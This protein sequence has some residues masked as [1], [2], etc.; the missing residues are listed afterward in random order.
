M[1]K[2]N[3]Y[4][5][6]AGSGKTYQLVREFLRICLG[7]GNPRQ[8]MRILAITFTNK[9]ANEMKV[10]IIDQL[11]EISHR[12]AA[13]R[14]ML[15]HLVEDLA[16]SEQEISLR[17]RQCLSSILHEYSAFSVSTIDG[18]TNRLIRSF[19]RDLQIGGNYEVEMESDEMLQEAVDEL[20][21]NLTE[22]N[23]ITD[24]ILGFVEEQLEEGRSPRPEHSLM[25]AGKNL[26]MEQAFHYLKS[27]RHLDPP[28]FKAIIS[29][30]RKKKAAMEEE[31]S[32]KAIETL[33]YIH[34]HGLS[35]ADFK[36]GYVY[37]Y[38]VKLTQNNSYGWVPGKSVQKVIDGEDNFYAA[39]KKRELQPLFEPI[40]QELHERLLQLSVLACDHYRDHHLVSAV[41]A[42]IYGTAVITQ[43]DQQL[44]KVKEDTN[45]LPIGE[46]NKL[47]SEKLT[48]E[49][50]DYLFE[51]L[52]ERYRYFF[53]D[54]FQDTSRLQWQ[55]LLPL[56]NNAMASG[57][58]VMLVGDAKQ[59]IY[60]WRG[61][62]VEQF[63]DLRDDTDLSNKILS[64]TELKELYT[65]LTHTL[66]TNY[67]SLATVVEFNNEFFNV[68]AA[69]QA[70]EDFGELYRQSSQEV[71]HAS[72]GYVQVDL[73][74]YD[75]ADKDGYILQQCQECEQIIRDAQARGY[76]YQEMAILVRSNGKG[77]T[78][79]RHLLEM[80][81]PVISPDALSLAGSKPVKALV[82]ALEMLNQIHE[83]SLRYHF[84]DFL[85]ELPEVTAQFPEK[86]EFIF[87]FS[88]LQ[89]GDLTGRLRKLLPGLDLRRLAL[90]SLGDLVYELTR[91]LSIDIQN[92]PFLHAFLDQVRNF[93][94]RQG[95]D[96][97][98]FVR[99]W[100]E[101]GHKINIS[102]PDNANAVQVMSVHKSKGLEFKICVLAFADWPT[103]HE[104]GVTRKWLSLE[105][106]E[107]LELPA[108]WINLKKDDTGLADP[109]YTELYARNQ[110]QVSFDNINLLY[111]AFT[112]AREELYVLGARG[113]FGESQRV[114]RYLE[115]ILKKHEVTDTLVLGEK[116][117]VRAKEVSSSLDFEVYKADSYREKL[118]VVAEA[119]EQWSGGEVSSEIA[120]GKTVH[121]LLAEVQ[122]GA[123]IDKAIRRNLN[124]G[125]LTPGEAGELR[126]IL[127]SIVNHP[128]LAEFYD[129]A[130]EV[131]NEAEILTPEGVTARPDRVVI[132]GQSADI[133]DYKT[134]VERPDHEQQMNAYRNLLSSMGYLPGYN[135]LAYVGKSIKVKRWQSN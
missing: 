134:G 18:F 6:S 79:A 52:G 107:D 131:L 34:E 74:P 76:Q 53:V 126:V 41:L 135:I 15:N 58:E 4:S 37:N 5:A 115:A 114:Y 73:L 89:P 124:Q 7:S 12:S 104:K 56:V 105:H 45:R 54:E 20:L 57:G 21:A 35:A 101:R 50:A 109:Q 87:L 29:N 72:G 85:S 28:R 91:I 80:G 98:G 19:A 30:L 36:S 8:F 60:R 97:P 24:L 22:E 62:E 31:V 93:E 116:A 133:I 106:V 27:L 111:V 43:I 3:I 123:D 112:R 81:I 86:H 82:S 100:E 120:F 90:L 78:I 84:L 68:A 44:Q 127:E 113:M 119:P 40:E 47:I 38:I 23:D 32:G 46:F 75:S 132:R 61:G 96:L 42:N 77:S 17:A 49:P 103:E 9:A 55:N 63:L 88:H 92:D 16:L 1:A 121:G 11:A 48:S 130:H 122:Q 67:R 39:S 64:G 117:R 59:S 99:W 95:E 13:G 66:P 51:R 110:E 14:S 2:F 69:L 129:P 102:T 108:A 25:T 70:G 125:N 26:F 33:D 10:R 118:M 128:E 94:M 71:H 65:R 83:R